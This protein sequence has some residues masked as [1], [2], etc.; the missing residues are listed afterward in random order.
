MP[1][2]RKSF[3]KSKPTRSEYFP[4]TKR[5]HSESRTCENMVLSLLY[6]KATLSLA[7][8]QDLLTQNGFNRKEI[9]GVLESLTHER[10][11]CKEGRNRF[12]LHK[13]APLYE[14]SLTQNPRGFGFVSPAR[15]QQNIPPLTR[16]AFISIAHMGAAHHGD[17]VLIRVLPTSRNDRPE[18]IVVKI[19]SHSPDKIGGFFS[20]M[21]ETVLYT[22]MTHGSLLL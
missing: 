13:T 2:K 8:L 17:K 22:Q 10:L 4:R 18:A 20:K 7:E 14:G 11:I 21:V 15:P 9:K 6:A 12:K 19:L 1:K 5:K 3:Q 16:D